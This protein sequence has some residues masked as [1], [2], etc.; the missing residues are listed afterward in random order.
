MAGVAGEAAVAVAGEAAVVEV[1][2]A[3][4]GEDS[5]RRL[6]V[7]PAPR[8]GQAPRRGPVLQS[9][10]PAPARGPLPV[11]GPVLRRPVLVQSLV[12]VRQRVRRVL[13]RADLM[14]RQAAV[15]PPAS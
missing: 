9:L 2:A 13:A 4:E 15:P 8:P 3:V 11:L 14:S 10:A 7:L 1:H 5:R 12:L 6:D